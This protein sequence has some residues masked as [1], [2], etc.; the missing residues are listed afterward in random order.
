MNAAQALRHPLVFAR[1]AL[2]W[3]RGDAL[4]GVVL[5][6]TL[7]A[8]LARIAEATANTRRN[9]A[10][11]RHVL[12]WGPPG[13]GKTMFAKG[14]ARATGLEYAILT[15]G[16]VAP[17]GREAVTEVHKVFDW[18]HTARRG[19]LVFVDEA[20]AF[21]QRRSDRPLSED[22]RNALNAFLYRTGEATDRFMLV[23]ATNQP[24]QFDD[25]I[26]DRID[27][28]VHFGLP[29]RAERRRMIDHY[30]R[31]YLLGEGN[32]GQTPIRIADSFGDKE[33]ELAADLTEGFS[34]REISKLAIAW[35]A[36]VYGSEAAEFTPELMRRTLEAHLDQKRKKNLWLDDVTK[37]VA[38]GFSA[39]SSKNE[40]GGGDTSNGKP[41]EVEA[42]SS[43]QPN[44]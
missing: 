33:V 34:G 25:A 27:E 15:G 8:R 3:G 39:K 11:F 41:I 12:L 13:T 30:L 37:E 20:D 42:R 28:M 44:L 43:L 40:K 5:E 38:Y 1:R 29:A 22:A 26:N 7:Q 19:V 23:Y 10:P 21:L 17:L 31:K 32:R 18:A 35:Q 2:G 14:L 6:P 24:E 36:A 9:R 4:E 16:D